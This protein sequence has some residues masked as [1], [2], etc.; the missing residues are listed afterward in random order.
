MSKDPEKKERNCAADRPGGSSRRCLR[1]RW[2]RQSVHTEATEKLCELWVGGF[3]TRGTRRKLPPLEAWRKIEPSGKSLKRQ[4]D[5]K[6]EGT[7]GDVY[8]NKGEADKM[9]IE[10][11]A[12]Y[13]KMHPLRH[14]RQPSGGL[15]A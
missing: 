8:E 13:T 9:S 4:K 11:H 7:S 12:F 3:A 6:N 15:L 5:V 1:V 10:K 2:G 14:H